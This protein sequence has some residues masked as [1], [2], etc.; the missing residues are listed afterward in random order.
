MTFLSDVQMRGLMAEGNPKK[1]KLAH[2]KKRPGTG[3]SSGGAR[4]IPSKVISAVNWP[5]G[6]RSVIVDLD[7][8]GKMGIVSAKF[9]MQDPNTDGLLPMKI[10][11]P[12]TYDRVASA[13]AT[14]LYADYMATQP[15]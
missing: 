5:A 7:G 10:A 11:C 1:A 6:Q 12:A 9:A 13:Q 8:E 4:F 2:E 14:Q 3:E 15:A